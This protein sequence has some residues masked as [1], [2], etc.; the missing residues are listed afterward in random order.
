MDLGSKLQQSFS[1]HWHRCIMSLFGSKESSNKAPHITV[2]KTGRNIDDMLQAL[3]E[4]A[5]DKDEGVRSTI[6]DSLGDIGRFE[7]ELMLSMCAAYL[8][9][10][11][12]VCKSGMRDPFFLIL[13]ESSNAPYSAVSF[14][15]LTHSNFN[16]F[17]HCSFDKYFTIMQ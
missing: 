4:G 7:P 11:P 12:K 13:L 6:A 1:W 8:E 15:L 9:R 10:N 14:S 2:Q 17:I 3:I 16:D 5:H